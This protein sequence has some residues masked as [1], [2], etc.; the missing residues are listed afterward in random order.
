MALQNIKTVAES[1]G[2]VSGTVHHF[3]DHFSLG[4][5]TFYTTYAYKMRGA[6]ERGKI[7]ENEARL[8]EP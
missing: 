2:V 5:G 7:N 4:A 8:G 3:G 1:A 6:E